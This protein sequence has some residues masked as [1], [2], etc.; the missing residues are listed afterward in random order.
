MSSNKMFFIRNAQGS[1]LKAFTLIELLVVIAI[2]AILAG[3]LLP[4]LNAAREKAKTL[5]CT[6]NIKQFGQ[7]LIV[8]TNDYQGYFPGPSNMKNPSSNF[9][10]QDTLA[11]IYRLSKYSVMFGKYPSPARTIFYCP[12]EDL[13]Y[14]VKTGRSGYLHTSYGINE[15][16]NSNSGAGWY[17]TTMVKCDRLKNPSRQCSLLEANGAQS[18]IPTRLWEPTTAYDANRIYAL[19]FRHGKTMNVS[20]ADGHAEPKNKMQI[21]CKEAYPAFD[22]ARIK[23]TFFHRG[24]LAPAM[25][26]YTIPGL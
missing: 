7:T 1:I 18:Y 4:A 6:S 19:H 3:L 11:G 24:E 10:W 14:Y 15:F 25:P 12:S 23:N 8:Y 21:P 20:F 5:S 16:L 9:Y 13:D 26:T 2:I 22:E 17:A